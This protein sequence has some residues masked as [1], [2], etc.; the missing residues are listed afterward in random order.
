MCAYRVACCSK[1]T[2]QRICQINFCFCLF[3]LN[4]L[5]LLLGVQYIRKIFRSRCAM[6]AGVCLHENERIG[7]DY[8]RSYTI[9]SSI[10]IVVCCDAHFFFVLNAFRHLRFN[11]CIWFWCFCSR[12]HAVLNA[13]RHLRFNQWPASKSTRSVPASAQRLSASKV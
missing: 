8:Q 3:I 10:R 2:V 7:S 9:P 12:Y 6:N 5:I 4:S 11:Q 1:T 13:F